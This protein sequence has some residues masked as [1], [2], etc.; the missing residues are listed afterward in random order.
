VA[1][2]E[3]ALLKTV[4]SVGNLI[5]TFSG[6]LKH[7]ARHQCRQKSFALMPPAGTLRQWRESGGRAVAVL[8]GLRL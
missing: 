7:L 6:K 8:S 4:L 2:V 5:V 3:A 1:L